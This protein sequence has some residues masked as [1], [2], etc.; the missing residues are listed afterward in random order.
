VEVPG[1]KRSWRNVEAL[2]HEERQGEAIG[3]SAAQLQKMAAFWRF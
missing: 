1:L 3:E 2:H